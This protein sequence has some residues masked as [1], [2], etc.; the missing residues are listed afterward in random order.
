MKGRT[1]KNLVGRRDLIQLTCFR[2]ESKS[3]L[4]VFCSMSVVRL[5]NVFSRAWGMSA[6]SGSIHRFWWWCCYQSAIN[7]WQ[8]LR[9]SFASGGKK[10]LIENS[11]KEFLLPPPLFPGDQPHFHPYLSEVLQSTPSSTMYVHM[12]A[13]PRHAWYLTNEFARG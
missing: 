11:S 1:E 2:P 7:F 8:R 3:C 9:R 6:A 13:G 4:L 10:T 12:L 5:F